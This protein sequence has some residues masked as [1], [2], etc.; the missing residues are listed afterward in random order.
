MDASY[1]PQGRALKVPSD[2]PRLLDALERLSKT[3]SM[4]HEHAG[5]LEHVA[6]RVLGPVPQD[7]SKGEA[8]SPP[9]NI[10]RRLLDAIS[11]AENLAGRLHNT[12]TRLNSAV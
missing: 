12:V 1:A 7:V 6:D 5:S 9:D 10:E 11:Y 2:K 3:L 4:C 8:V